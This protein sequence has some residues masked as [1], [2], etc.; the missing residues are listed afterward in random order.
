[1]LTAPV[2]NAG[3]DG[4]MAVMA[5]GDSYASLYAESVGDPPIDE[6]V[7]AAFEVLASLTP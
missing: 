7:E 6:T 1:M 4:V 3:K 5:S 2:D